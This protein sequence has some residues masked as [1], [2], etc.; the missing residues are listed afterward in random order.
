MKRI[1]MDCHC[2]RLFVLSQSKGISSMIEYNGTIYTGWA[3]L[4]NALGISRSAIHSRASRGHCL[5]ETKGAKRRVLAEVEISRLM[6]RWASV[7]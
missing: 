5:R 6:N 7:R 1:A 2:C 3:R 4:A